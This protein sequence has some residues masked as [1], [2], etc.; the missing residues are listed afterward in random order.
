MITLRKKESVDLETGSKS[1]VAADVF[2]TEEDK[3]SRLVAREEARFAFLSD[4][5]PQESIT[6]DQLKQLEYKDETLGSEDLP[7]S[8]GMVFA[9]HTREGNY[10]SVRI[11][12][13]KDN[14]TLRWFLRR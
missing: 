5:Q 13:V 8:T 1:K 7:L 3:V 9:V 6:A 11:D 14:L 4:K 12:A 2:W 10:A